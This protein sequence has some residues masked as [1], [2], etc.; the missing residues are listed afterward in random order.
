MNTLKTLIDGKDT[1]EVIRD[2]V[3]YILAQESVNQQNLAAAEAGKNP[4]DYALRV[5]IERLLPWQEWIDFDSV[6][7]DR[8]PIVNVCF[9]SDNIEL[10]SSS[11]ADQQKY[12]GKFNIDCYGLGISSE[13]PI[14]GY[15]PGDKGS[16]VAAQH[17][18]RIVRNI[19]M[20]S[21]NLYFRFPRG[22]VWQRYIESRTMFQ[23]KAV[24]VAVQ[25]VAGLRLVLSVGFTEGSIQYVPETLEYL[26]ATIFRTDDDEVYA[27]VDIDYTTT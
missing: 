18:G 13:R 16:A 12:V 21:E 11:L 14:G 6:E 10:A 15:D 24:D 25:H 3:A 19:L 20:A 2:R 27:E 4:A 26:G 9:D 17:A 5:F 7:T 23:P 22:V 8:T 1:F